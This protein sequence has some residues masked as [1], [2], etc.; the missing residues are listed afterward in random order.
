[1]GG[2]F[3]PDEGERDGVFLR[4]WA[5]GDLSCNSPVAPNTI[6]TLSSL[7]AACVLADVVVRDATWSPF[8]KESSM[9]TAMLSPASKPSSFK[10]SSNA[11]I[12]VSSSV[13]GEGPGAS[14]RWLEDSSPD[15][16]W[17][18]LLPSGDEMSGNG[19]R[20]LEFGGSFGLVLSRFGLSSRGDPVV[21]LPT[22]IAPAVLS[23]AANGAKTCDG[24]SLWRPG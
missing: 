10:S 7:S 22:D 8:A 5:L 4:P 24:G 3:N 6:A 11:P 16:S 15:A 23:L 17:V 21:P 2:N 18:L 13:G 1:M 20:L 12:S 9:P 19:P 14:P